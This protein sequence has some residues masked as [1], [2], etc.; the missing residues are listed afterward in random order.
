MRLWKWDSKT[1]TVRE[2]EGEPYPGSDNEGD[3]CFD[4]THFKSKAEALTSLRREVEAIV[5]LSARDLI[6]AKE[7]LS[8]AQARCGEATIALSKAMEAAE[9]EQE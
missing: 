4:N 5:K 3:T 6:R 1:W 2:V 8:Q 7:Q 9:G